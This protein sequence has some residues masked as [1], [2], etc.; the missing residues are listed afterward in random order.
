MQDT[1]SGQ[2]GVLAQQHV[3][4]DS[5]PK[6]E[7]AQTP[8]LNLVDLIASNKILDQTVSQKLV[9]FGNAQVSFFSVYMFVF[10]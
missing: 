9:S 7:L 1:H 6:L 10:W 8:L 5:T 2:H 4:M 3:E